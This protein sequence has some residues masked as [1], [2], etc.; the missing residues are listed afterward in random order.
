VPL[1][2]DN[3]VIA[4]GCGGRHAIYRPAIKMVAQT[5]ANEVAQLKLIICSVPVKHSVEELGGF[6]AV[7]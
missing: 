4:G 7:Y 2:A 1:S 3:G 5:R 6:G